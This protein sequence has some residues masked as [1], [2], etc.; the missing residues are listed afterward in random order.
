M[1]SRPQSRGDPSPGPSP[2]RTSPPPLLTIDPGQVASSSSSAAAPILSHE[3]IVVSPSP[4]PVRPITIVA[5]FSSPPSPILRPVGSSQP[6][7][8]SHVLHPRP[9]HSDRQYSYPRRS[10][11]PQEYANGTGVALALSAG[12]EGLGRAMS[13]PRPVHA[14]SVQA[15]DPTNGAGLVQLGMGGNGLGGGS[16]GMGG[17]YKPLSSDG[18]AAGASMGMPGAYHAPD[19]MGGVSWIVPEEKRARREMTV[20]ERLQPT[21]DSAERE[22]DKAAMRAKWTGRTLNGAIGVQVLLGALTTGLGAALT[23]KQV[24]AGTHLISPTLP[25]LFFQNKS[26]QNDRNKILTHRRQT[27]VAIS[28]LGG[29]VDVGGV[30]PGAGEGVERAPSLACR[31]RRSWI[32]F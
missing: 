25:L 26:K 29:R 9:P 11:S 1:P 18:G 16:G 19:G 12:P 24:R 4:I 27:S 10:Q 14:R 22:R 32:I 23:G 15:H 13:V 6:S 28:I 8:T 5:P 3:P 17:G 21:I 20:G 2:I 7:P 30:V 31:G